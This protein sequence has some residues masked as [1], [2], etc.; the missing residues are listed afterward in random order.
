MATDLRRW[1]GISGDPQTIVSNSYPVNRE[2]KGTGT[3]RDIPS[4]TPDTA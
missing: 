1:I 2:N 4:L 3:T